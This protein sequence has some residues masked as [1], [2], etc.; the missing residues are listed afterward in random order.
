MVLGVLLQE[1]VA[2]IQVSSTG[3]AL[4][5]HLNIF[6]L[7]QGLLLRFIISDG[8]INLSTHCLVG[9]VLVGVLLAFFLGNLANHN[10][11]I[12]VVLAKATEGIVILG[13]NKGGRLGE[14]LGQDDGHGVKVRAITQSSK[15]LIHIICLSGL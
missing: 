11:V 5:Q 3:L 9:Q 1:P 6:K 2:N 12:R 8:G 15:V 4:A 14:L 7:S 10:L 13:A